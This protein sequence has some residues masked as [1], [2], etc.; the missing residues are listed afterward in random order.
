MMNPRDI[1]YSKEHVWVKV[2]GTTATLGITD[3]AQNQ[4]G[5]VLAV[6]LPLLDSEVE[7][8]GEL[9]SLDCMKTAST[10]Y[11]P[12]SGKVT[13]INEALIDA[14]DT[15]NSDPYG[16]GWLA[17]VELNDLA[18]LDDLMSAEEYEAFLESL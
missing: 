5:E 2:D 18:E 1:K 7:K 12:V 9:G 14:P 15:V 13:K 8:G 6:E 16:E 10:V 4:L 17:Q 11:A 3:Y